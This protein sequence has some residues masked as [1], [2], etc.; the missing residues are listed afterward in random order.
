M[1]D[2]LI[3]ADHALL[4]RAARINTP[5]ALQAVLRRFLADGTLGRIAHELAAGSQMVKVAR[6]SYRHDNGFWKVVLAETE[7]YKLRVHLWLNKD[8]TFTGEPNIHNH[9]W[10]FSSM[11]LRGG[12][13]QE[14][15]AVCSGEEGISVHR[16]RYRP[17][18][19][20]IAGETIEDGV[21]CLR[22]ISQRDCFAGDGVLLGADELHRVVPID[23]AMP[24]SVVA[25][26]PAVRAETDVYTTGRLAVLPGYAER[27]L[28]PAEVEM[29]ADALIKSLALKPAR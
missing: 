19:D 16:W 10:N 1:S 21:A 13:V 23:N 12:Y 18:L 4:A 9:R 29:A 11:L 15:F 8:R 20:G 27:R 2:I 7:A 25:V 6:D 28:T 22:R 5:E 26:G 14:K 3:D 24:I 17:S